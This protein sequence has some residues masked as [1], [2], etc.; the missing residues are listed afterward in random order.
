M[1]RLIS[2]LL[3]GIIVLLGVTF[4]VFIA[5]YLT[6]DPARLILGETASQEM[7][8]SYR[9]FHGLND[10][11]IVQYGRFVMGILRGDFGTS[12]YYS[13]DCLSL[14]ADKL[15]NTIQ[16]ASISLVLSLLLAIPLGIL[17]ATRRNT[18]VDTSISFFSLFGQS[19]P[20]FWLA[21]MLMLVFSVNNRWLPVSGM[22]SWKNFVLPCVTLMM[23]P[24]AQNTRMMRSSMIDAL[25]SDYITTARAKGLR[26][27]S[28]ILKHSLKNALKPTITMVGL[29]IGSFLGGSVVVENVF[30][31]DGVGRLAVKAIQVRDFPLLQ[32][33]VFFLALFFVIINLI[34]DSL[35]L[36]LDPRIR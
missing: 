34:V 25:E 36:V 31:W 10:P 11:I 4:L 24:L 3:Q 14:I 35:Y 12:L 1:K 8:E 18:W 28:V 26:Q 5:S 20:N 16:L 6:G 17:S 7:I 22:G 15:V 27:G 32:S 30:S 21:L 19:A 23:W 29:Q 9:E 33:I 13:Q 2:R